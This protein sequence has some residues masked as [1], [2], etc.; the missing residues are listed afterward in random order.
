MHFMLDCSIYTQQRNE[1]FTDFQ[2]RND[3]DFSTLIRTQILYLLLNIDSK[4]ISRYIVRI[5]NLRI[6]TLSNQQI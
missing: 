2:V 4:R 5:A 3:V 6:L 1:L